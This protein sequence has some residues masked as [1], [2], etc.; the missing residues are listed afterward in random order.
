MFFNRVKGKFFFLGFLTLALFFSFHVIEVR[1]QELTPEQQQI[2]RAQLSQIEK[3]IAEQQ[4]ILDQKKKEGT[5]ISGDISILNAQIRKAQLKIKAH[6]IAIKNL[7]KDITVK[8]NTITALSGRIDKS[9]ESLAQIIQRTRE[10]DNYSMVEAMLSSKGLSEFFID[11][12]SYASIKQSMATH[13]DTIEGAKKQNE[14]AKQQLDNQRNKEIDTKIN[15]Q[16]E[17]AIIKKAESQKQIL[18]ALNKDQ[19]KSYTSIIANKQSEA[20]KIRNQLFSLRDTASIKFGD[21]VNYAKAVSAKTG[22]SAAFVLAIIQQESNLGANVGQ[23]YLADTSTGAGTKKSTGATVLNVMKPSRDVLPFLEITKALG[24][25]PYKTVVS[26]PFTVGYGGAMGPAQFIPSTWMLFK[27]RIASTLGKSYADPW[28]PQDAFMASGM[29]LADLG[30][31]SDSYTAQKNA[32]CRYYSGKS[33]SGSN[34]FYGTQVMSKVQALQNN[35]DIIQ[36]N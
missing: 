24:R 9:K 31:S 19:Q 27:D 23:C 14:E 2:L 33:C 6:E 1:A 16:N 29:Y 8:S 15:I 26:C 4:S 34:T 25:D 11:V 28:S 10:M 35:I 5:S 12:D 20:A 36:N 21:A 7:G 30:A 17:Q 18:L 22:V 3:E 32:A 13:I